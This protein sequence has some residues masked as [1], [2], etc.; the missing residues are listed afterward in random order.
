MGGIDL[1]R[2]APRRGAGSRG[3]RAGTRG[4]PAGAGG[5]VHARRRRR[6]DARGGH[7][8]ARALAEESPMRLAQELTADLRARGYLRA[9]VRVTGPAF[10]GATATW[11]ATLMP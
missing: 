1:R 4:I 5:R 3:A 10:E 8:T 11:V 2:R 6:E 7:C 9:A